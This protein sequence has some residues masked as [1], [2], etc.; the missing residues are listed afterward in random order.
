MPTY[1]HVVHF[2]KLI[3]MGTLTAEHKPN[4]LLY[5]IYY[6]TVVLRKQP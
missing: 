5:A 1:A 2:L 3:F 4:I 6:T